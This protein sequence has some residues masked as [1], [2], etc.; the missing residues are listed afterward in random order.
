MVTEETDEE[1][2]YRLQYNG[3]FEGIDFVNDSR[4]TSVNATWFALEQQTRPVVWICGGI[5]KGNDYQPL[6]E[7][8]RRKVRVII[9][10]GTDCTK[11]HTQFSSTLLIINTQSMKAAMSA[12]KVV[13]VKGDCI[14]LSPACAS[15]DLFSNFID[16]GEQFDKCVLNFFR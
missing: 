5:D 2:K 12:A 8:V 11:I 7:L 13:A 9:T 3:R 10:L 4:S 14:L 15:F 6:K 16:R 1:N